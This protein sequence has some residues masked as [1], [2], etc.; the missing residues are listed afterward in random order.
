LIA[1]RTVLALGLSQLVCWGITYYLIGVLGPLMVADLRWSSATVYGGFSVSLLVMAASSGAVGRWLDRQ[2]GAWAMT[3]GSVVIAAGCLM[4]GLA[5]SVALYYAA[6]IVLGLAMRLT[7]YDAAF[8]TLARMGGPLARRPIAQI[9]LLGGLAST[10]FW[11]LGGALAERYGWRGAVFAYGLI[12]LATIPLHATL[13]RGRYGGKSAAAGSTTLSPVAPRP[14]DRALAWLYAT[15]VALVAFLNTAMS[16]HMIAILAALG[17]AA[18]TAVWIS[19]AR[20]IGQSGARLAEILFGRT[21]DPLRLNVI[22]TGVLPIAFLFG[23]AGAAP[24]AAVAFSLVYGAG[25]GVATITRGTLPL[26]L[27]DHRAYG[28]IVGRL[29]MPSFV[30]SAVAPL[31]YAEALERFGAPGAL[32]LSL[33]VGVATLAASIALALRSRERE[34]ER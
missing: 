31:A 15:I 20:G 18:S 32:A 14:P 17:L 29:L 10:V 5:R 30:L 24:A 33:A 26:V 21:L 8:A 2:G 9:T 3:V 19:A 13:P 23:F 6:W 25:N 16:S 11:P 34:N 12:A 28:A 1:T 7:L 22:A 27:F 4:L